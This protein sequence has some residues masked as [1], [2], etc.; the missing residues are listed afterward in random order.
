MSENRVD[1]RAAARA[2]AKMLVI[3]SATG[4]LTGLAAYLFLA[5]DHIGI[6]FL[7]E[8]LP[9]LLPGVPEYVVAVGV[10]LSMTA[11]A[12]LVMH[13][14]RGRPFDMGKAEAEFDDE[15]KM[16]YRTIPAG[17]VFSLASLFS[18]AAVG[19]EAPLTD[20]S[21]GSGSW[22]GERFG[23]SANQLRILTYAGV[24]GAFGAFFGS[25][26]VGALLAAELISPKSMNIS[27][28]DI[29]AGLA[30]GATGY[31]TFQVLGGAKVPLMM[32]F[33]GYSARLVDVGIAIAI[34]AI[35]GVVGL[36]YAAGLLKTRAATQRVRT[37]P[38]MA[39]LAGGS[40]TAIAAVVSPYLLF[41]GQTETPKIIAEGAGWG[42]AVLLGLGVA[43]LALSVWNLTTAYFGGPLFP[44]IFAGT[45]FGMALHVAVPSIPQGVA[46]LGIA[47]GMAVA[48]TAAPLSVTLFLSLIAEPS[49]APVIAIAAV[50]A[51]VVRQAIAPTVPGVYRAAAA[52]VDRLGVAPSD[53]EVQAVPTES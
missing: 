8:E 12:G 37:R 10:V 1:S 34:G 23:V 25:A 11:V 3:A 14:Y 38:L 33:P 45:C 35:G 39:V 16:D 40:V 21:G 24:A 41:S 27:R 47:A 42:I 52:K 29:A 26:P 18:G 30:S 46:V 49:L 15:G 36:A 2:A 7:W 9:A 28:L 5:A 31:V 4:A 50:A 44:L 19:P 17:I 53:A 6:R 43:K 13:F 20:I 51:F 48:A 22:V 32:A